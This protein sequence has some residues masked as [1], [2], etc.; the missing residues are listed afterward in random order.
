MN[1]VKDYLYQF[2]VRAEP[3]SRVKA[4]FQQTITRV[5]VAASAQDA[6]REVNLLLEEIEQ[7]MQDSYQKVLRENCPQEYVSMMPVKLDVTVKTKLIGVSDH[8]EAL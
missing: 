1:S 5:V 2:D 7:L 8:V 4:P 3:I 6:Q